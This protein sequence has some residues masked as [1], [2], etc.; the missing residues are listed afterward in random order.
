MKILSKNGFVDF[1]GFVEQGVS[2]KLYNIQFSDGQPI[3]ATFDHLFLTIDMVWKPTEELN[4]GDVLFGGKCVIDIEITNNEI[5]YDAVNV[6]ND[7]SYYTNGVYSHNCNF[8]YIDEF[9]IIP[10]N[11]AED[12]LTATYPT[13]S[14]GK[15]T[16]IVITS[17]PLGY[18]HFWHIWDGAVK[19]LNGF[20]PISNHYTEH[21]ARDAKWAADQLEL[22]GEIKYNQEV[23]CTFN[24][25]SN[26]L[27]SSDFYTK[28]NPRPVLKSMMGLDILYQPDVGRQYVMVCDIAKGVGRDYSTIMI[29]DITDTPYKIVAKYRNNKISDFQFPDV[30]YRIGKEY[31]FADVLIEINTSEQVGQVLYNEL[32]YENLIFVSRNSKMGQYVGGGFGG[33]RTQYGVMTDR[34]IKRIGCNSLK[35]LIENHKMLV[36]DAETINEISTFIE[37]QNSFAADTGYHDDL[38]MCL[39]LFAWLSTQTYFQ[40]MRNIDLRKE[41]TQ[42]YNQQLEENMLPIGWM[43]NGVNEDDVQIVANF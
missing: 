41:L 29:I 31:N 37:K 7:H 9:S 14:S 34:K 8:L 2:L 25:S 22:L 4:I 15:T 36:E 10:N 1:D 16:K 20:I 3:K 21:P 42:A 35:A 17:T 39:V 13:I 18:N 32:E 23:L 6:G 12:F 28:M 33:G 19:G 38:V 24:G 30:I 5:V 27:I 26:T 40:E 11:I 43:D